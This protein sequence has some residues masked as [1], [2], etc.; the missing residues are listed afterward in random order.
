MK[1]GQGVSVFGCQLCGSRLVTTFVD[2]GMSPPCE[3]FVPASRLEA[4]ETFYPLHV[5]ICD[6]CLL[7]QLPTH[8]PA[9]E[10]FTEN[11]GYYSSYST[12]WVEHARRYAERMTAN[13]GLGSQSLVIEVAS[14]DGYLLQH[15]V[16]AGIPVLGIEP[17]ANVA[18][19]AEARGVRT[20]VCFLGETTARKL[21]ETYGRADLVTAN[22][23]LAHVPDLRDFVRGLAALVNAGGTLTLEFPHVARLIDGSQFDTIYHEHFSYFTLRTAQ[24]ALGAAGLAVTDVE[25]L[26][27][28][29]GSLR[30][31]ARHE[32]EAGPPSRR[33]A[34]L[35]SVEAAAGLHQVAGYRGFAA[36]VSTVKKELLTFLIT[37]ADEG[38]SV[39]GYG[40]PGKG[41]TLLNYCGIRADLL[42]F[43]VDLNPHKHGMSLPGTHIPIRPTS[44]IARVR[45]DYVLVL[46]WNLRA[47]I[48]GQLAYVREWG[49]RLVYPIPRLEIV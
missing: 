3:A 7:V 35:L 42:P 6:E 24:R 1:W 48:S 33:V 34:A 47:E 14:N 26:P 25:E 27:T 20:E 39:A 19:A 36:A 41:N 2:L 8:L 49:G 38:R 11:Y 12:S 29:G 46:P 31:H 17:A 44:E 15:F 40:A 45:P 5:R 23:V 43:T 32:D 18:A 10:L 16:N 28:H 9:D 30:V 22:N 13:L 4:A 21:V 37:A